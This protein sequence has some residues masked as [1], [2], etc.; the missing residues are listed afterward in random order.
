MLSYT[1]SPPGSII[2]STYG[3]FLSPEE[4]HLVIV[5]PHSISYY[6]TN[7]VY[8]SAEPDVELPFEATIIGSHVF[9]LPSHQCSSIALITLDLTLII[10]SAPFSKEEGQNTE[11]DEQDMP[12]ERTVCDQIRSTHVIP[13]RYSPL[14]ASANNQLY[15]SVYP[16]SL[17]VIT[18]SDVN[19]S[20]VLEKNEIH[21][22]KFIPRF[23][24]GDS[25]NQKIYSYDTVDNT[26]KIIDLEKVPA[27]LEE[28]SFDSSDLLFT[29]KI[30]L[31]DENG[32]D[33]DV[34]YFILHN[35]HFL[36]FT[37]NNLINQSTNERYELPNAT[38]VISVSI[39]DENIIYISFKNGD[40]YSF[41][42][43][44]K[45]FT[46]YEN[47]RPFTSIAPI[48]EGDVML[49]SKNEQP[50]IYNTLQKIVKFTFSNLLV[51]ALTQVMVPH[52]VPGFDQLLVGNGNELVSYGQGY[53][54]NTSTITSFN[55]GRLFMIDNFVLVSS[56]NQTV[57][58]NRSDGENI[59]PSN[60]FETNDATVG[61]FKYGVSEAS[62]WYVQV[63]SKKIIGVN[64]EDNNLT[65]TI[66]LEIQ[67]AAFSTRFNSIVVSSSNVLNVVKFD[68]KEFS[69]S[70]KIEINDEI[71]SICVCKEKFLVVSLWKN[72]AVFV[73]DLESGQKL[74]EFNS[75]QSSTKFVVRS[76][77]E[78]E[79]F[80]F[81][82]TSRGE[83]I[84]AS[85]NEEKGELTQ[86]CASRVSSTTINLA[87]IVI[88]GR[89]LVCVSSDTT[90][91][92]HVSD[93][94]V[95]YVYPT[96][97]GPTQCVSQFSVSIENSEGI[98]N[99]VAFLSDSNVLLGVFGEPKI[100]RVSRKMLK[101]KILKLLS[102]DEKVSAA[103]LRDEL[104]LI[105][106]LPF[107]VISSVSLSDNYNYTNCAS[108]VLGDDIIVAI[109]AGQKTVEVNKFSEDGKIIFVK[110]FNELIETSEIQTKGLPTAVAFCNGSLFV[111]SGP[112]IQR[113]AVNKDLSFTLAKEA[114]GMM[115]CSDLIVS[116]TNEVFNISIVDAFKSVA[117]FDFDLHRIATDFLAKYLVT[118]CCES[119]F[120]DTLSSFLVT[121]SRGGVYLMKT[122]NDRV[123]VS[124]RMSL[125]EAVTGISRWHPFDL[126]IGHNCEIFCG[127]TALGSIVAIITRID[128]KL[129][130]SL[131]KIQKAMESFLVQNGELSHATYRCIYSPAYKES[132]MG[133][134][135]ANFISG[136]LDFEEEDRNKI[137]SENGIDNFD[138]IYEFLSLL[139][140]F[141]IQ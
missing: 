77:C 137:V 50:L 7:Q 126:E 99:S 63:C 5:K 123:V 115:L 35:G 98:E 27:A 67:H 32:V 105:E 53:P 51:N 128:K 71:S 41:D 133:Y 90:S 79:N 61:F 23:L 6:L 84:C 40:F 44:S 33:F 127:T 87:T 42:Q 59:S 104:V 22:Q 82:G 94:K 65:A 88:N 119:T 14:F 55:G 68:G 113:Y 125:G 58:L 2:Y 62:F 37:K 49:F 114:P 30:Q 29:E 19:S 92:L 74:S 138:E 111:T 96:N 134:V 16:N 86:V 124:A 8:D 21:F 26:I 48:D 106:N 72:L 80:V 89:Q 10:L 76:I 47:M 57:V 56:H 13:S 38:G 9:T 69:V 1:C 95:F 107:E 97:L 117:V 24:Y 12:I 110:N 36:I 39:V 73:Y 83:V 70:L 118:G 25:E 11:E 54:F 34:D 112:T 46:F 109:C 66:D 81:L 93:D 141:N 85:L 136:I 3:H 135:D 20:V 129:F 4:F 17:C 132:Y 140:Q 60:R 75:D 28:Q 131:E 122:E 100:I 108:F 43:I 31:K 116:Q 101:S 130:E 64:V 120:S 91:L 18:F 78:T 52:S 121:D 103:L 102:I 139:D 45:E 15:L